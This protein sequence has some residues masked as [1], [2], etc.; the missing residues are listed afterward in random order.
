MFLSL[1][2][3]TIDVLLPRFRVPILNANPATSRFA[4]S[5]ARAVANT[6]TVFTATLETLQ[7]GAFTQR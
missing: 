2:K 1:G 5:R 4:S 3:S 7:A 6:F